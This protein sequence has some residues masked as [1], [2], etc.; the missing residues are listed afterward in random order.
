MENKSIAEDIA[1]YIEKNLSSDLKLDQ[2]AEH[3]GYSKFYLNRCFQKE[4]GCTIY[5]YIQMRRM[6]EAARK[7]A[8][9]DQPIIEVALEANYQSQQAFTDAF[10]EVYR[11]SPNAYRRNQAFEPL[12][13]RY[14]SRTGQVTSG[15]MCIS[16]NRRLA[17]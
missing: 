17:A 12:M 7:L 14:R 5:K 8:E 4:V 1:D 2:V 3:A 16:Q 15:I 6:T 13:P 11:R 9:S 10:R